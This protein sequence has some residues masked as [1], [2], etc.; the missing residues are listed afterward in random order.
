MHRHRT[1]CFKVKRCYSRFHFHV[2]DYCQWLRMPDDLFIPEC[3]HKQTELW[4]I[5]STSG[6]FRSYQIQTAN[7]HCKFTSDSDKSSWSVFHFKLRIMFWFS[8]IL[9]Y[10]LY[11]FAFSMSLSLALS[12]VFL[13]FH[14]FCL[15]LHIYARDDVKRS[16]SL[17]GLAGPARDWLEEYWKTMHNFT[18]FDFYYILM[19]IVQLD[20]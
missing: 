6:H 19:L 20:D 4:D 12:A 17:T 10:T 18:T 16:R 5:T 1:S 14:S 11:S 3:P 2:L 9:S 7:I 15:S 13:M 8:C